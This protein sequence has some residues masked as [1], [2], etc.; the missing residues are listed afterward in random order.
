MPKITK[1]MILCAGL[2]TRLLPITNKLPKPL[3]PVL[4]I[5]NILHIVKVMQKAGINEIIVNTH[6]LANEVENFFTNTNLNGLKFSFSNE[7][8]LLLGTGGGVKKAQSFFGK[9]SFVLSNCDFVTDINLAPFIEKHF[10]RGSLA[11]MVLFQD[12]VR[13]ARYS[14]VGV[15]EKENLCS[16]PKFK[17]STPTKGGIF[18]GLHI[19]NPKIFD[20]LEEKPSG[21]NDILY[22][23]LMKEFPQKVFGDFAENSYWYD[24]GDI[25]SFILATKKLLE[26]DKSL[27]VPSFH[28]VKIRP[29]VMIGEGCQIESGAVIGPHVVMGKNCRVG[30]NAQISSAVLLDNSIVKENSVLT[31]VMHWQN[32][33]LPSI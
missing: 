29:P 23:A 33:S 16:L 24:T 14:T 27:V 17:R 11:T 6:H 28:G 21:I 18:T 12:E 4:N 10:Q 15:D 5:P 20:Y 32:Q 31:D 7:R 25:G 3:V 19:L 22:P 9:D 30:N 1:G 26:K 8:S 13:Q 2:G